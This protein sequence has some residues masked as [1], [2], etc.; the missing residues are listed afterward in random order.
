MKGS[1]QG[2]R[3]E[4]EGGEFYDRDNN[5]NDFVINRRS[6]AANSDFLIAQQGVSYAGKS[7][8]LSS[9]NSQ[10]SWGT[11][12]AQGG[13]I[14]TPQLNGTPRN[15]AQQIDLQVSISSESI[16][17]MAKANYYGT[18]KG[19]ESASEKARIENN[20]DQLLKEKINL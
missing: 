15:A 2:R 17:Q 8:V 13:A 16:N 19:V 7:E 4:L 3:V 1:I 18:S 14:Y 12:F 11:K 9:I 6:A 20:R 10:N 5:G